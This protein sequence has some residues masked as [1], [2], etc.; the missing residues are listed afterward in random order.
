MK[1]TIGA[2]DGMAAPTET[3]GGHET[4]VETETAHQT[5]RDREA[6]TET[7]IETE[8]TREVAG[9]MIPVIE[10]RAVT[11]VLLTPLPAEVMMAASAAPIVQRP[12]RT[13]R[14][15]YVLRP[16]PAS[17][18]LPPRRRLALA[19]ISP[20]ATIRKLTSGHSQLSPHQLQLRPRPRRRLNVYAKSKP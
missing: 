11:K 5:D 18:A 1:T 12:L 8:N 9:Q 6:E 17:A 4:G 15:R 19:P 7:A 14:P 16:A 3:A 13:R 2:H 20:L 10:P